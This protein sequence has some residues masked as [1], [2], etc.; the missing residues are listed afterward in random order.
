MDPSTYVDRNRKPIE[1]G[2]RVK[3]RATHNMGEREF[4]GTVYSKDNWGQVIV[5]GPEYSGQTIRGEYFTSDKWY[6]GSSRYEDGQLVFDTEDRVFR[7][8]CYDTKRNWIEVLD[9]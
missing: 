3:V 5:Q 6:I 2:Q 8:D 9:G 1:I 4:E 7:L